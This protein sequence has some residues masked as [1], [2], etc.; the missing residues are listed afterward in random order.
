MS[1]TATGTFTVKA[2]E[3][4]T[5]AEYPEGGKLTRA[6]IV[7][8]YT[9]ELT[10]ELTCDL[11]MH[12]NVDGTAQFVGYQRFV[13]SIGDRHGSVVMSAVGAYNKAE[14]KTDCAIVVGSGTDGLAG[15][16]G[17]GDATVG[18]GAESGTYTLSYA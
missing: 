16:S 2:F 13:G 3:E 6:H 14:A 18:H 10:G 15:L 4:E 12:Y 17:K 5:L 8:N 7:Q 11:V 9:G 1:S